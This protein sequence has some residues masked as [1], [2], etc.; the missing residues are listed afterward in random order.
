MT[1]MTERERAPRTLVGVGSRVTFENDRVRVWEMQLAPGERSDTHRHDLDYLLV[2]LA[3]DRIHVEP[4][5]DTAGAYTDAMEFDVPLGRAFFVERGG[6][7]TAVNPGQAALPRDPH[8]VEG[9]R[10]RPRATSFRNARVRSRS[11]SRP[12]DRRDELGDA[13]VG[14]PRQLL[15]DRRLVADDRDVG[16]LLRA[17]AVEHRAVRRQEAVHLELLR[18]ALA[19][20]VD[21]VGHADRQRREH[22]RRGAPGRRRRPR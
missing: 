1:A 17:L 12:E 15:L 11:S 13:R 6:V 10:P 8:R 19:R 20:A 22:L 14:E 3:G 2:F 16:R 7:E 18:R 5:P 4:E 9:R 21:V